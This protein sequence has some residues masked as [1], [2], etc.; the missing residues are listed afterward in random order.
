MYMTKK[1]IADAVKALHNAWKDDYF[2]IAEQSRR[3]AQA[4]LA[5]WE[6]NTYEQDRI[7]GEKYQKEFRDLSDKYKSEAKEMFSQVRDSVNLL[8]TW[9]P[10]EDALRAVTAFG[11]IDPGNT[12]KD[13]YQEDLQ[14]MMSKYGDNYMIAQALADMGHKAGVYIEPHPLAAYSE[15][16]TDAEYNLDKSFNAYEA[17]HRGRDGVM[18]ESF[19][20]YFIDQATEE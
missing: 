2:R 5:P 1:E 4:S 16:V 20:D 7:Y 15:R 6:T 14:L 18:S 19:F 9:T 11:L 10:S 3:E 12:T 8:K 17:I 13:K